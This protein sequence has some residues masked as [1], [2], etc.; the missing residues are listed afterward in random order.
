MVTVLDHEQKLHVS[1]SIDE[2]AIDHFAERWIGN[3]QPE[4]DLEHQTLSHAMKMAR[5]EAHA[6]VNLANAVLADRSQAPAAAAIQVASAARATGKRVADRLDAAHAK[7][8]ATIASIEKATFAPMPDTAFGT[9][10]DKEIRDSLKALAPAQRSK[11]IA[12]ALSTSDMALIGAV[13][14]AHPITTGV[15]TGELNALRHKF[16]EKYFPVE[17]KRLERLIKMRAAAETGGK[18]FIGL[19]EQAADTK[20]VNGAIAARDKRESALA[21]HQQG[22]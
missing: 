16:R 21:A 10:Y 11:E 13:L 19:V 15:S 14:R 7:V 8:S 22:A 2:R 9:D 4:P 17:M 5:E 12:D 3:A 6:L 1:P 18:A 20:Y